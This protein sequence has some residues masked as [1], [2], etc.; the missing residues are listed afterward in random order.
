MIIAC[1]TPVWELLQP[2]DY[3]NSYLLIAMMLCALVGIL[4]YNPDM[5]LPAF[6]GFAY[7]NTAGATSYLFPALF[8]TIA[9]GAVSGFHSLVSSGTA[10]KQIKNE[11]AMLPVSFGA[12]LLESFL[13]ITALIAVG[14]V[15]TNEGLPTGNPPQ[16]FASA[17]A[18]FMTDRK[19]TRLNSSHL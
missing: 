11:K 16:I 14:S 5:N 10:S 4:A 18:S 3:L 17:I 19:S 15:A 9:C 8:V 13:A 6:T 2:R 12:M 1:V 7:T